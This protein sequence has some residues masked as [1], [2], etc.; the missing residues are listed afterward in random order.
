MTNEMIRFIRQTRGL[1]LR[2]FAA[3]VGC[4]YSY[5]SL[6]ESGDRRVTPRLERKIRQAFDLS[7]EKLIAIRAVM[8]EVKTV[9]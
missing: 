2:E 9:M 3:T 6:I 8:N 5:I 1:T 7:D 4:S